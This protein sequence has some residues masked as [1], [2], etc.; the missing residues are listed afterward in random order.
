MK[1]IKKKKMIILN[2]NINNNNFFKEEPD[3]NNSKTKSDFAK[4]LTLAL[5][6]NKNFK[7]NFIGDEEN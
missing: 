7:L 5:G 2:Y 6:K 1:I 4:S 3:N